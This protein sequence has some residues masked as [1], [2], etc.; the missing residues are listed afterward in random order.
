MT[1]VGG[2]SWSSRRCA[3]VRRAARSDGREVVRQGRSAAVRAREGDES[4]RAL[5]FNVS[6]H[7]NTEGLDGRHWTLVAYDR[8]RSRPVDGK[9]SRAVRDQLDHHV[10][11]IVTQPPAAEGLLALV[12]SRLDLG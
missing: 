6:K 1:A 5:P 9:S 10:G 3:S 12:D 2:R 4:R 11:Q 7:N 8:E